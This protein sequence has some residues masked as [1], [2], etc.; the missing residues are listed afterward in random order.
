MN[1]NST[2]RRGSFFERLAHGIVSG[3]KLILILSVLVLCF[4]VMSSLWVQ[5]NNDLKAYLAE[6]SE[7]RQGLKVMEDEFETYY[8][9]QVMLEGIDQAQAQQVYAQIESTEGVAMATY[10]PARHFKD[11]AALF[12]VTFADSD[13]EQASAALERVKA[14][15]DGYETTVSTELGYNASQIVMGEMGRI[16]G[17]AV[18]VVIIVLLLTSSTYAEVLVLILT[19]LAA[20]LLQQ[21]T[22]FL[23]GSI[24]MMSN[25]TSL[26]LQLALSLDYAII[27]CNRYKEEHALY[28]VKEAVE[29]ALAKA[30][31]EVAASSLTTVA[32]LTAMTFMKFKLGADMGFVLIKSI[33][34]SLLTV[35]LVMPGLLVLFG[36]WMDKTRH[37]SFVPKL[38]F[39]GK[40]AWAT[41]KVIPFLFIVVFLGA[42]YMSQQTNFAY[43][44]DLLITPKDNPY[45]AAS[46]HISEIFGH[47]NTVAVL[48]PAGNYD[49]EA[50]LI[51]E[52]EAREEVESVLGLAGIDA[53]NGYHIGDHV[54]AAEF[55]QLANLEDTPAQ[56]LFAYYGGMHGAEAAVTEDLENYRVP[57]ID[58]FLFLRDAAASGNI[59]IDQSQQ[60][61]IDSLYKKLTLAQD[62]LQG[63]NYSRIVLTLKLPLE[64]P[65]TFAFLD[66]I[67]VI[68][69]QYYDAAKVI[70]VGGATSSRDFKD[71]FAQD[72]L[73][74]TLMSLLLVMLI[75]LVTFRS[76]G[77][78]LM[79]ILVIQ[80]SICLNFTIAKLLGNYVFFMCYLIVTAIQMG[81]NIDYAIVISSRFRELRGEGLP[82]REAMI[83]TVNFALPTVLTSGVIMITAGLLIGQMVSEAVIAGMGHYVG[84][85]TIITLILVLFVLPQ[86]LLL[87][88]GFAE[89]TKLKLRRFSGAAAQRVFCSLLAA[90]GIFALVMAPMGIMSVRDDRALENEQYDALCAQVD[91]LT[92][93]ADSVDA[94]TAT[95]SDTAYQ[96][97]EHALTDSIGEEKL[98]EGQAQYDAGAAELAQG[99]AQYDAGAAQ[100][101]QGQAQY[102]AGQA[103]LAEGRQ[104][105][106]SGTSQLEFAKL[107]YAEAEQQ[108]A[109]GEVQLEAAK[110]EYA[111]GEQKLRQVEPIYNI[112]Q[113][114]YGRYLETKAQYDQAVANGES[115]KALLLW[116]TVE[117]QRI[118]YEG[119][120]GGYSIESLVSEYEAGQAQLQNG[121]WEIQVAEQKLIE[122]KAQLAEAKAQLEAGA[123]ELIDAKSQLDAGEAQLVDS[124]AQLDAGKAQLD[125]SK[126]QLDAGYSQL[127][128]AA[129]Q[130]QAGKD[131]LAENSEALEADLES[132]AQYADERQRLDAGIQMLA[133]KTSAD[134]TYGEILA[135]TKTALMQNHTDAL[136][137]I[138][139][140]LVRYLALALGG[141]LALIGGLL[142]PKRGHI[143]TLIAVPAAILALAYG[144]GGR[145]Q[146]IAAAAILVTALAALVLHLNAGTEAPVTVPE[147]EP[148]VEE[149]EIE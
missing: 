48:V 55:A 80:G 102:D 46:R 131:Q 95:L 27:F 1:E 18:L 58:L 115:A 135:N 91:T 4:C 34:C 57:L 5:T 79:L 136:Q 147:P 3:R 132:L 30:I 110:A 141:L 128:Q 69:G 142:M 90:A 81:A 12:A 83:E 138:S 73:V 9:A 70:T 149:T 143:L 111:A 112:V 117:A 107:Q 13:E 113:P 24:S 19:F 68:A 29:R 42:F 137:E 97:A 32:G 49:K 124:K 39:I 20:A 104:Q 76:L 51:E 98:A 22:N 43:S 60:E 121:A 6:D 38:P 64:G 108:I 66:E 87:G 78:P 71:A 52:L 114:L 144:S 109:D 35:F 23:L 129:A 59:E 126:A 15:C 67:H 10:D 33:F 120:L 89:K 105:Y 65:A 116:P 53:M 26:I 139:Q 11:G 85:G 119:Q 54:N 92:E 75:L 86:V 94:R 25:S 47:S 74:V 82:S 8:T 31:P 50:A 61:L 36:K 100:L 140:R 148:P 72:N 93:L 127:N 41:R 96:F 133:G 146:T 106:D 134:L 145:L 99:Q 56:A 37:R 16:M 2:A 77:M 45:Q 122:G 62:Q 44:E 63:K 84:T 101:A 130:L 28:P 103:K 21:G 118:A 88:E 14:L 40:F 125:S 123:A 17:I 7:T